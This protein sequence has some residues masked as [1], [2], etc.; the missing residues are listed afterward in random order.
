MAEG[1]EVHLECPEYCSMKNNS[2]ITKRP[3]SHLPLNHSQHRQWQLNIFVKFLSFPQSRHILQKPWYER[4]TVW[5]SEYVKIWV[6]ENL[7]IC[8]FFS[9]W[10]FFEILFPLQRKKVLMLWSWTQ[11]SKLT[12]TKIQYTLPEKSLFPLSGTSS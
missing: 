2:P 5:S 4:H 1:I 9:R 12:K 11:I 8:A 10:S 3:V 7:K 6:C